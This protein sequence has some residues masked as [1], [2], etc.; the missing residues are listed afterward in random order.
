MD[1]IPNE[2]HFAPSSELPHVQAVLRSAHQELTGLLHQRSQIV[3]RI[4]SIKQVL[5]GMVS[6]FGEAVLDK[7]LKA[8]LEDRPASRTRGFTVACRQILM[9]S[10]APV[11]VRHC[12]DQMRRKFPDLADRHKDLNASINTVLH[13]LASYGE[14]RCFLDH[15]GDRLWEWITDG[16]SRDTGLEHPPNTG[17]Q[18]MA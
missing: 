18:P 3:Q 11:P 4:G 15:G 14:A 13:R 17:M 10:R 7:E 2:T 5:A 8:L 9:Q 1:N 6:L 12:I 16:A